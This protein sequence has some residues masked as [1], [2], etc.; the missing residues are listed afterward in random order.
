MIADDHTAVREGVK[1]LL[2]GAGDI[3]LVG[4]A[5]DAGTLLA[6]LRAQD[7]DV[8]LLDNS[9]PGRSGIEL[10]R[11]V[12]AQRPSLRVLL[13]GTQDE[14]HYA[15][16]AIRAG[17][18]GYVTRHAAST[19]LLG[20]I[21][22]VAGSGMHMSAEAARLL[23]SGAP[24]GSEAAPHHRLSDREF[25]VFR[26]IAEGRSAVDIA[27]QLDLSTKTVATRK[28][29]ILEKMEMTSTSELI[30][31]AITHRLVDDEGAGS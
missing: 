7:A 25:Q 31:Y 27:R 18:S 4:E 8:A 24:S 3:A 5:P 22:T 30:R 17:A 26:L 23:S 15:V 11:E 28:A 29:A 10:I 20:A 21:R 9:I 12:L 1:R 14:P 16:R 13:L 19:Q 2:A 6:L